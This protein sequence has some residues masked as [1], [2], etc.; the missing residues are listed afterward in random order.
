MGSVRLLVDAAG[1]ATDRYSYDGFGNVVGWVG[2][3]PNNFL[4][5]AEQFD[6]AL[7][8][9]NLRGRWLNPLN[10]RFVTSDKYECVSSG[11]CGCSGTQMTECD[12]N[13]YLYGRANP[14]NRV[15][16]LGT[17]SFIEKLIL[18]APAF[19]V[20]SGV[21]YYSG[22]PFMESMT[23]QYSILSVMAV[24]IKCIWVKVLDA[25]VG[26]AMASA[27]LIVE[28]IVDRPFPSG[29]CVFVGANQNVGA[30]MKTCLYKCASW[31][32]DFIRCDQ[33]LCKPC[34]AVT[35]GG[36]V[37]RDSNGICK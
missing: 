7:G 29:G 33:E 35:D 1:S 32:K 16:P 10:G 27:S 34:P 9:Y 4:Y 11:G 18:M 19:V 21:V 28:P 20:A 36:M 2:S 3:N 26:A 13:P 17:N 15:D 31:K 14:A 5:R 37:S 6:L 30:K 24:A 8:L 12:L 22:G 25:I 23:R